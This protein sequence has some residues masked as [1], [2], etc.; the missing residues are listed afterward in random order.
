MTTI[1]SAVISS[2]A[3]MTVQRR[4]VEEKLAKLLFSMLH[5]SDEG[6]LRK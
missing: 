4:D 6:H 1:P 3:A 5:S 2:P